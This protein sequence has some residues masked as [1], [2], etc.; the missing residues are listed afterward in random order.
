MKSTKSK[1]TLFALGALFAGFVISACNSNPPVIGSKTI[2]GTLPT[3]TSTFTPTV[4]PTPCGSALGTIA[5]EPTPITL[6]DIWFNPYT[7]SGS[8]LVQSLSVYTYASSPATFEIGVYA[9]NALGTA[10]TTLLGETG[11]HISPAYTG[12]ST[13]FMNSPVNLSSG[14]TYW[15]ASLSSTAYYVASSQTYGYK[16]GGTYGSLP[17]TAAASVFTSAFTFSLYGTVCP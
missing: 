12:W 14:V 9:S 10:P 15:L 7:P 3:F 13:A 2:A 8:K 11:P 4:T 17:V 6:N 16:S 5:I 1:L